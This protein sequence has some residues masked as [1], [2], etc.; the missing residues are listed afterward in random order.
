VLLHRLPNRRCRIS[1]D[2]CARSIAPAQHPGLGRFSRLIGVSMQKRN[3]LL[4]AAVAA[5]GLTVPTPAWAEPAGCTHDY[6]AF[7]LTNNSGRSL[8]HSSSSGVCD[9]FATR[10]FRIEIKQDIALAPDPVAAHAEDYDYDANY[11]ASVQSCDQINNGTY[12]GR[13]FF[14]SSATYHDSSH[15]YVNA[16]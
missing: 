6:P 8:M 9:W 10:T 4:V 3:L 5:A 13:S 12:Y 14:T 15:I 11:Y 16:C 7:W 1:L 2:R